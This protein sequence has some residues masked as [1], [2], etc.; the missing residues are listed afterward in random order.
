MLKKSIALIALST[1][2]ACGPSQAPQTQTPPAPPAA[3]TVAPPPPPPAT[4][5]P[6]PAPAPAPEPAPAPPPPKQSKA[7]THHRV[8]Q[9]EPQETYSQ[10]QQVQQQAPPVCSDCGVI[11]GIQEVRQTGQA[12]MVGT[13]G[14]AAAG[15]LLGN[16][17]GHGKGKTAMTVVGVLGGALAGREVEK[18]VKATT[19]SQVTVNM[20]DGTQ[21][22]ITVDALNGLGVGSKVRVVGNSLQP[23]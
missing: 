6:P 17:F 2:V 7:P 8:A 16:Q 14:G 19:V 13:L 4:V 20:D 3:A 18:Q 12:G 23:N 1:L 22:V 11:A 9:A 21:R 10:Q 5:A 15:G